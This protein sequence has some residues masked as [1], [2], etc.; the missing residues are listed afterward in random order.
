MYACIC[1]CFY[2]SFGL[3]FIYLC[4]Y[5]YINF[6]TLCKECY[7]YM[8]EQRAL[9]CLEQYSGVQAGLHC[10]DGGEAWSIWFWSSIL[11]LIAVKNSLTVETVT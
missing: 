1:V 11:L 3:L 5:A 7:A 6:I 4:I 9:L 2:I 8:A 10:G